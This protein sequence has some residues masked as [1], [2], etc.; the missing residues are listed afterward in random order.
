MQNRVFYFIRGLD[1]KTRDRFGLDSKRFR[2]RSSEVVWLVDLLDEDKNWS[3]LKL[4]ACGREDE[5]AHQCY[6]EFST[7]LPN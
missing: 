2:T 3:K 5:R 1:S 7:E 4:V 6:Y